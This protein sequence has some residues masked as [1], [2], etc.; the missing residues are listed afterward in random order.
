MSCNGR[1]N[2][3][4]HFKSRLVLFIA[5]KIVSIAGH[6]AA[7]DLVDPVHRY[8]VNNKH[9]NSINIDSLAQSSP[10][11]WRY[12]CNHWARS[13]LLFLIPQSSLETQ[14]KPLFPCCQYNQT[15]GCW[16]FTACPSRH[17][18]YASQSV[19][20]NS[21]SMELVRHNEYYVFEWMLFALRQL[22]W[23]VIESGNVQK[24]GVTLRESYNTSS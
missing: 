17:Y 20:A 4:L 1:V 2:G 12:Y 5:R 3:S 10:S 6:T 13:T 7:I 14:D 18:Y 16:L 24:N 8:S 19:S 11:G 9:F 21:L 23:R 22:L 15:E